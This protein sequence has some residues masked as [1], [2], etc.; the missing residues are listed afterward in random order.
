[1]IDPDD[2]VHGASM[3]PIWGRQDTGGPHVGPMNFAIWRGLVTSVRFP[4]V[5]VTPYPP[6]PTPTPTRTPVHDC[7]IAEHMTF[8]K[9]AFLKFFSLCLK[10]SSILLFGVQ[11]AQFQHCPCQW[12]KSKKQ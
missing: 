11:L 8:L 1:M 6:T 4:D 10:I 9:F 3:G 12:M 2:K 7:I 5:I